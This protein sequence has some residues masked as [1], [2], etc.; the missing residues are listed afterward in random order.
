MLTHS[1]SCTRT[2]RLPGRA[3]QPA[4]RSIGHWR[5]Q[6][7]QPWTPTAKMAV[8]PRDGHHL[9][10]GLRLGLR[11]AVR[12]RREEQKHGATTNSWRLV[13]E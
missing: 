2:I 5:A 9:L 12:Q 1:T 3:S 6:N 7:R 4:A 8:R 11:D 13:V 10:D